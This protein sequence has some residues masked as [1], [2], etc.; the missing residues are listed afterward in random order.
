[1]QWKIFVVRLEFNPQNKHNCI[2]YNMGMHQQKQKVNGKG[3][4]SGKI[5][6]PP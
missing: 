6:F 1:M 3:R 2:V 5:E 4:L